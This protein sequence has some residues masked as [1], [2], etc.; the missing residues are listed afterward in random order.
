MNLRC[1]YAVART[2]ALAAKKAVLKEHGVKDPINMF[3]IHRH[4]VPWIS[5]STEDAMVPV[6]YVPANVTCA[7][8]ILLSSAPAAQ[9]DAKLADWV[10]KAP[11]VL[12]NL[13]SGM[14][15]GSLT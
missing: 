10:K 14:T 7:G 5:M 15:V 13:G 11:T 12:V 2:P 9:Q 6:Q 8:P 4:D 1:I 3:A